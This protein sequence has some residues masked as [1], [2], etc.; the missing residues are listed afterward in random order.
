M[1]TKNF[2][3]KVSKVSKQP[4]VSLDRITKASGLSLDLAS[5]TASLDFEH[6]PNHTYSKVSPGEF[7][8]SYCQER[9]FRITVFV[10]HAHLLNQF[11]TLPQDLFP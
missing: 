9:V 5:A 6:N 2:I 7:N 10:A 11:S 3:D 4:N 1:S 8:G